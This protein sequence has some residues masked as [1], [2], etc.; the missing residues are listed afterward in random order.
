MK[1]AQ[2]EI[3]GLVFIVALIGIGMIFL[4]TF[5][6]NSESTS[7]PKAFATKTKAYDTMTVINR[8]S[9]PCKASSNSQIF[10]EQ[11]IASCAKQR[12]LY[13]DTTPYGEISDCDYFKIIYANV[14]NSTLEQRETRYYFRIP[15]MN[16]TMNYKCQNPQTGTPG[17]VS[18]PLNPGNVGMYLTI[19]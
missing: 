13:C 17:F 9:V 4:F 10:I 15:D 5:M 1:K 16:V 19:C 7:P 18:V 14:L 11:L 2:F 8:M 12:N 6:A 3:I